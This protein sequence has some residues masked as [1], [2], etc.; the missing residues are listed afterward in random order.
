MENRFLTLTI[1]LRIFMHLGEIQNS[2]N[3]QNPCNIQK[4]IKYSNGICYYISIFYFFNCVHRNFNF[5]WV[6]TLCMNF[7]TFSNEW[8]TNMKNNFEILPIIW[9]SI[10]PVPIISNFSIITSLVAHKI[11][12][13][14]MF[15]IIKNIK[16]F[17]MYIKVSCDKLNFSSTCVR[18]VPTKIYIYTNIHIHDLFKKVKKTQ[19]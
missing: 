7:F 16:I 6:S 11:K 17:Y 14:K 15:Y 4:Y 8:R 9:N 19:I 18:I 3:T 1:R 13:N 12:L 5:K 2:E 10:I